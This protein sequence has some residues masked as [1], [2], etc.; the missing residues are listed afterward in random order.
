LENEEDTTKR[1]PLY[2]ALLLLAI[3]FLYFFYAWVLN[4]PIYWLFIVY[5]TTTRLLAFPIMPIALVALVIWISF[6]NKRENKSILRIITL[7]MFIACVLM[8]SASLPMVVGGRQH[9]ASASL[10]G[11]IY[12][13]SSEW[14]AGE[15][16]GV[17]KAQYRLWECDGIGLFCNVVDTERRE[18]VERS[19]YLVTPA[20]LV[21]D[22]ERNEVSMVINSETVYSYF[23]NEES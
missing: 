12:Y 3:S 17:T 18:G 14:S 19:D 16:G 7:V 13:L 22:T 10:N 2:I 15:F 6:R 4:T 21:V 8:C 9:H 23:P 5:G 20:T 11:R 1:L